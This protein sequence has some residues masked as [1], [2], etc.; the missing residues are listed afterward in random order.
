[1]A[2][3]TLRARKPVRVRARRSAADLFFGLLAMLALTAL[4]AGVPYA[5]VTVV[6]LPLPQGLPP[7]SDLTQRLDIAGILRILS[8]IV[9]L[10]WLQL[11]I[12]VLV[13][14]RAAARGVGLPARV[15]LSGPSQT[16]ARWLVTAAMLVV[17]SGT[18]IAPV[19]VHGGPVP[20]RPGHVVS[21]PSVAGRTPT[22]SA[23]PPRAAHPP[24]AP[25]AA[26]EIIRKIY[27]VRPPEGR[28]HDSL[29]EIAQRYLG[30]GRRYHEIFAMNRDRTQPDGS[31]ITIASLI[32][33]GWILEL[34][35]DARG[36]G[37]QVVREAA[38]PSAPHGTSLGAGP[39]AGAHSAGARPDGTGNAD[40]GTPAAGTS[41]AGAGGTQGAAV[42]DRHAGTSAQAGH[43]LPGRSAT[44]PG[45][46]VI[47]YELAAAS[48]LAAGVLAAL[49]RQRRMQLW[50]RA[51]G[52]RIRLPEGDA[53]A[54][55]AAL[56]LG[57][58]EQAAHA[59]DTGLRRMSAAL[60]GEGREPPAV[61]AAVVGRHH[62]DLRLTRA[63]PA[64]PPPW[65]ARDRGNVWRLPISS[66]HGLAER[67]VGEA[68]APYPGL[69]SIGTNDDGRVLIDPA[70]AG[71]VIALRGPSPLVR[72]ALAA[73]AVELATSTWSQRVR[74]TLVGFGAEMRLLAPDRVTVADTIADALPALDA[75]DVTAEPVLAAP[76]AEQ[77]PS[78]DP[79]GGPYFDL[80][81]APSDLPGAPSHLPGV[82]SDPTGAVGVPR[83]VARPPHYL[84]VAVTPEAEE[85]ERLRRLAR[86]GAAVV[87]C[88]V[89][90][91]VTGAAWTFDI[92]DDGRLHAG[93]LGLDLA[94]QLVPDEQYA[95]VVDLFR[96]AARDDGPALTPPEILSAP[97]AQLAPDYQAQVRIRLLGPVSV[98]APG[99]IEPA[100]SAF[101]TELVVYVATHP[102]GV[103]PS[104]LTAALWP[105]GAPREVAE[106]A[107]GRAR[108]WLGTDDVG[109]PNLGADV[110]GR[111]R[112]GA[113]VWVDW[114]VL[115]A[116]AA[117]AVAARADAQRATHLAAAL[118]LVR[119]PLLAGHDRARYTWLA[120]D[121]F[122]AEVS[123]SV[124][125]IAHQL[126]VIRLAAGNPRG[127]MEAARGGLRLAGGDEALW[128]DMLRAAHATGWE[129]LLRD[130]VSE[131]AAR[132]AIDPVLPRMA[133][134]TEALI[135]E[136]LPGWRAAGNPV[137]MEAGSTVIRW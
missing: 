31:T 83:P 104:V 110:S 77:V 12:C 17:S 24:H 7:L 118:D 32:R 93:E 112:L 94:A 125:D 57:A 129:H 48:L 61:F 123:A 29:W 15:P 75:D 52:T 36:P 69:V 90:G 41:A 73:L 21:A 54:A 47:P 11:S 86:A 14:V 127:A 62:L 33:P 68:L 63:D 65:S 6:G 74:L 126:A 91:D 121:G 109:R 26:H 19:F 133:P 100:R 37:L 50:N 76:W 59:I 101:T 107:V 96:T 82:A 103:H 28:H 105:R 117:R 27:V 115:R 35:A 4:L 134:E 136:L 40:Q 122:E 80:P 66:V 79:Y 135:D 92:A 95:S 84:L 108:E 87:G 55:E 81:G 116:H 98:D 56:R 119:G 44:R 114:Q 42:K 22:A 34:P 132:V 70:A 46:P 51:F 113:Q 97:V 130:V 13:E 88:V 49:G 8:A 78:A 30:D 23:T 43:Y 99:P 89:A 20:A 111:L 45:A 137:R 25:P 2:P 128:R 64:A 85:A 53:A 58:D 3:P 5:L 67:D 71:G 60:A 39:A 10:A 131:L 1:M 9:W 124:A 18:A 102:E 72:G 38:A 106:A 120:S 16:L